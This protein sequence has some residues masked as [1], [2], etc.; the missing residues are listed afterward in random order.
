MNINKIYKYTSVRE[1]FNEVI[2][3]TSEQSLKPVNGAGSTKVIMIYSPSGGIGKTTTAL[4]ICGAIA[5]CNKRVLYLN[6]ETIQSY[7][8]MLSDKSFCSGSF[9]KYMLAKQE[10]IV[11]LLGG[12]IGSEL[13]DYLKPFRQSISSLNISMEHYKYL[14]DA[15]KTA[16]SYDYIVVD[17]SA[18]FTS[19]K[20]MLMS[21]ADKTIIITGQDAVSAAK[22]DCLL[23]NIDCSDSSKFIFVCNKYS[24]QATNC[25]IA[26]SITNKC[27]IS[28]Y[29]ECFDLKHSGSD[30]EFLAANK[31]LQ[32]LAYMLI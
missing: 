17:T 5:K 18:D 1:I 27:F 21:F 26:G 15:L 12:A 30:I 9:E 6:T 20:T 11:S 14:I 8:L 31:H 10:N 22:L 23:S 2:S 13:F 24:R 16:G 28:E 29:I 3:K 19:E 4:G 7:N 25:L 32:K